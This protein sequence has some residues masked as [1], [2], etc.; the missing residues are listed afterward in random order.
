MKIQRKYL[1]K[2]LCDRYAT[3]CATR[4]KTEKEDKLSRSS[5]K[6]VV[7]AITAGDPKALAGIDIKTERFGRQVTLDFDRLVYLFVV[8]QQ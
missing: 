1:I 5:F 3:H 7:K 6:K 4:N 8:A 2:D